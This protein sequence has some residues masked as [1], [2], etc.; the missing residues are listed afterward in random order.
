MKKVL[1]AAAQ[2]FTLVEML[3]AMGLMTIFLVVL[4]DIVV[5]VGQVSQESDATSTVAEDGRYILSR[6]SYD[7]ERATSVTT[8]AA[9]GN[10]TNNLVLVIGG[11]TYTYSINGSNNLQLV[12]S[13]NTDTLNGGDTTISN[14]TVQRLGNSGGKE[15]LTVNFTVT[16]KTFR[17]GSTLESKTYTTTVGRR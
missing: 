8:P 15:T 4:S 17:N 16:S 11:V 12:V 14:F 9:L 3:I 5:T 13:P 6:L 7:I 10:T 1:Q 2:G